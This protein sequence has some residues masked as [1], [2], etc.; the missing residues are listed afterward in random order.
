MGEQKREEWIARAGRRWEGIQRCDG[1]D[2]D[3]TDGGGRG[4]C[5]GVGGERERES[6]RQ[7]GRAVV[8]GLW[9]VDCGLRCEVG[10]REGERARCDEL[11]DA[12][13]VFGKMRR[14]GGG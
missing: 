4:W 7:F 9:S 1:V 11:D 2:L 12:A 8:C 6:G 14:N 3:P 13:V 5:G 10:W